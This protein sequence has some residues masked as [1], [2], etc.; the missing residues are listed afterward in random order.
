MGATAHEL[1]AMV[2]GGEN[3]VDLSKEAARKGGTLDMEDF[4]EIHD[5][6]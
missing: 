1:D 2:G 4:I 5:G 3:V 6:K